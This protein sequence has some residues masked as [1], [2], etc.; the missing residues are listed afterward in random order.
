MT[1]S[2]NQILTGHLRKDELVTFL[3]KHP[4]LFRESIEVALGNSQPE[5]WRAAWLIMHYMTKN[6]KRI[7]K[8]INA[9]LKAL[10]SRK[11]GHQRELLKILLEMKLTEKQ[12]GILFDRCISIWEDIN[13]SPS[14]RSFAFLI[15]TNTVKKYPELISEIEFLTQNHYTETLSPGIRNSIERMILEL[16]KV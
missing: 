6:D 9:I 12:E 2:L 7:I 15:I 10:P 13:K 16:F 8:Y 3:K 5:A 11:D 14:V 1:K 4:D